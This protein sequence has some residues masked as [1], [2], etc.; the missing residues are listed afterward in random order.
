M[1]VSIVLVLLAW[2]LSAMAV[3]RKKMVP[4]KRAIT[5][6]EIMEVK[7]DCL[8]RDKTSKRITTGRCGQAAHPL[9]RWTKPRKRKSKLRSK[10]VLL[11]ESPGVERAWRRRKRNSLL[12][13]HFLPVK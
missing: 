3:C 8:T 13:S 9:N 1:Q 2:D 7:E 4:Q 6:R 10:P 11:A 5:D 12:V